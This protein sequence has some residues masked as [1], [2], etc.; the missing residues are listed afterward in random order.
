MALVKAQCTN[1]GGTLEVDQSKDA[2][3]CP[4]CNTP[5]VVEKAINLYKTENHN[6][7]V[8]NITYNGKGLIPEEKLK[9]A[10]ILAQQNDFN[11][12][13]KL[14][15]EYKMVKP[16]DWR[17]WYGYYFVSNASDNDAW[18]KT[19]QYC[20]D[21]NKTTLSDLE[22]INE[23]KNCTKKDIQDSKTEYS[24][25]LSSVNTLS[26]DLRNSLTIIALMAFSFFLLI[27]LV[28]LYTNV[29]TISKSTLNIFTIIGALGV[30]ISGAYGWTL[31]NKT[32]VTDM[33]KRELT[34]KIEKFE[35]QYNDLLVKEKPI[36]IDT[37]NV[38][39]N[40]FPV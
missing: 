37:L 7:I 23:S 33:R 36:A 10:L 4:F 40:G 15:N 13:R 9:N 21:D 12:S 3:I 24:D 26:N 22:S 2:A 20:S 34:K 38:I 28:A 27:G 8:N 39:I 29:N 30:I 16:D 35:K 17:M 25:Y 18:N 5:Y 14:L 31:R 6:H 32:K 19:L 11:A 1:C